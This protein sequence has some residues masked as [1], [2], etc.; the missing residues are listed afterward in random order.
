M[1]A[2]ITYDKLKNVFPE[3]VNI[4]RTSINPRIISEYDEIYNPKPKNENK[5]IKDIKKVDSNLRLRILGQKN[6]NLQQSQ[7]NFNKSECKNKYKLNF[8]LKYKIF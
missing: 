4:I 7:I 3:D 8:C 6:D 2:G 5:N 1:L